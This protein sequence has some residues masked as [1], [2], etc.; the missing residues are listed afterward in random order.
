MRFY[1][2][3]HPFSCGLALHVR[4]LS[5]CILKP[6][7]RD[8]GAPFASPSREAC[9]DTA[10]GRWHVLCSRQEREPGRSARWAHQRLEAWLQ[11]TAAL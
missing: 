4:H 5:V 8:H 2:K 10:A 11:S 3:P 6:G 1:L 7:R 9:H